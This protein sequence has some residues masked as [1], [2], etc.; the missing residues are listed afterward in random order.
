MALSLALAFAFVFTALTRAAP[1]PAPVQIVQAASKLLQVNSPVSDWAAGEVTEYPIHRSCNGS[2]TLLLR[3]GLSEAEILASHAKDHIMRYG[4]S[5]A[6][7]LKY[8]GKATTAEPAGW[9][10][11]IVNYD[12]AGVLFRCDDPDHNC[13]TQD[14]ESS[15]L[16][17]CAV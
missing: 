15:R 3:Q 13:A 8:F 16:L 5:S 4:N 10:D 14:G 7:F 1:T 9:F 17:R 11:K 2:E 12:K 6:L